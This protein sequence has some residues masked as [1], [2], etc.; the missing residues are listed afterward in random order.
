MES[1]EYNKVSTIDE[2]FDL[3]GKYGTSAKLLAGDSDLILMMRQQA[4]APSHL[5]D[6][7][8][9]ANLSSIKQVGD[10]LVIG[11]LVTLRDIEKSELIATKFP[12]LTDG[13]RKVA[14]VQLRNIATIGGNLCQA[15]K[16]PY[17]N[18]S[19]VNR[20]MK[21]SINPC[22]RRGG[23]ECH[24][25]NWG[26]DAN[27]IIVGKSYCKA[28]LASDIAI[29]LAVLG[30]SVEMV[31]RNSSRE[32]NVADLYKYDSALKIKPGEILTQIKI[33]IS[34]HVASFLVHKPSPVGYSS[35]SVAVSLSINKETCKDI[36]V[37]LGGVAPQPYKAKK[38]EDHIR[39]QKLDEEI[40]EG[41]A[42]L[43]FKETRVTNN[44]MMFKIAK[45]R[46]LC[47]EALISAWQKSQGGRK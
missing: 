42:Q 12:A 32:I 33:P 15:V 7:K 8:G 10:V 6:L 35:A 2:A 1:F 5:I 24:V 46:D 14:S 30:G 29:V 36:R 19:H 25:V 37:Y 13:V 41:S 34:N 23:N 31:S 28:P 43:L 9:I 20:F 16:C 47:R 26:S 3:L 21:Q 18:Q 44:A 27:N 40:I 38:V 4:I 11:T 39:G 45:S 17:Y 22:F